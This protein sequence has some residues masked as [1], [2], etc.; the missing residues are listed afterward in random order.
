MSKIVAHVGNFEP[1][2]S[3]ENDVRKAFESLGWEV[4]LLQENK[5]Q[6]FDIRKVAL[7]SDLL[8]WTSTWDDAQPF[9]ESVDTLRQCAMFGV[10]TATLHLDLF[11]G[12]SRDGRQ[13]WMNPMLFTRKVFT[14]DGDNQDNWV[15]LGV[16]HRWLKPAIRHD[17]AHFGKAREEYKCDVAFLGSNGEG[18]HEGE[19]PYR[20]ELLNQLRIIC[21]KNGWSFRNPG[22]D[23]P[24]IERSEDRNDFYASAT[25]TVGD[26]LCLQKE[27]TLYCSDRVYE[28][29]GCG[30]LLIMPQIDF[31]QKD[32][33]GYLPMYQWGDWEGLEKQIKYYLENSRQ[34]QLTREMCQDITARNHTYVNRVKELLGHV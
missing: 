31:V 13:W 5:A 27:K 29:T 21:E 9:M 30:G 14:A 2:F 4:A 22:G 24:K 12:L 7:Q 32:F 26:S 17:A 15:K 18:Y 33:K 10:P 11:W 19:W 3:T 25:V 6:W 23:E 28:A 20:K 16:D 1:E 34:N 8:L